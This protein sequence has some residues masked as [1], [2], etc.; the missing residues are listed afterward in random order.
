MVEDGNPVHVYFTGTTATTCASFALSCLSV[1][2]LAINTTSG[3]SSLY[4]HF[5]GSEA[6][7]S[8]GCQLVLCGFSVGGYTIAGW[9]T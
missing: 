6:C 5:V 3:P 2:Y 4:W 8:S 1:D 7:D 9:S